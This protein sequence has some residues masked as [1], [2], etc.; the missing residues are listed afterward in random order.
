MRN[1][2][3]VGAL[4][5]WGAIGASVGV[6]AGLASG[7]AAGPVT[8]ARIQPEGSAAFALSPETPPVWTVRCALPLRDC[9]A[10]SGA[11]VLRVGPDGSARLSAFT[12]GPD[13]SITIR[14]SNRAY[15]RNRL[16]SAPLHP[17]DVA[18]LD[19][20]SAMLV[21]DTPAAVILRSPTGGIAEVIAYLAWVQGPEAQLLR[22]ARLWPRDGTLDTSKMSVAVLER[23]MEAQRRM[24]TGPETLVPYTKPQVE[25]AIRAQGGEMATLAGGS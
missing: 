16:F 24:E 2:L 19:A 25:F 7:A 4:V 13:A 5:L 23:Y 1:L 15:E 17:D 20:P 21:I 6:G 18:L 11:L 8:V 12:G 14:Q 3:S 9:V 22:D 10:R